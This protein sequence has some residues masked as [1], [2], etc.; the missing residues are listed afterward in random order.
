MLPG[1]L[2]KSMLLKYYSNENENL[3]LPILSNNHSQSLPDFWGD[4]FVFA[5]HLN[6]NITRG[7][8]NRKIYH[9]FQQQNYALDG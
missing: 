7:T 5:G 6:R 4:L 2:F 8:K 9:V 1:G 3:Q